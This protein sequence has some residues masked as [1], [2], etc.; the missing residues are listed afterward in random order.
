MVN[1]LGSPYKR[2]LFL[3]CLYLLEALSR[4]NLV[5]YNKQVTKLYFILY[6]W[7]VEPYMFNPQLHDPYI[8]VTRALN[9]ALLILLAILVYFLVWYIQNYHIK[10]WIDVTKKFSNYLISYLL[11]FILSFPFCFVTLSIYVR[12]I[13]I[14]SG[15]L[16]I[17]FF[18]Y[19]IYSHWDTKI[20]D[21]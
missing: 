20:R 14:S 12:Y 16:L 10:K 17:S 15:L 19:L 11:S 18:L 1:C 7:L 5:D 2:Y 8:P 4:M 6:N 13:L 9:P 3:V 21:K